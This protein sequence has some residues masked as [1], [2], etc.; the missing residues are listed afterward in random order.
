MDEYLVKNFIN[1]NYNVPFKILTEDNYMDY[2]N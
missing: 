2:Y 1:E